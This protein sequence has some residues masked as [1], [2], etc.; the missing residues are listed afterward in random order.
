MP[1]NTQQQSAVQ[2]LPQ[3]TLTLDG[4]TLKSG[5]IQY[6]IENSGNFI[7]QSSMISAANEE[8]LKLKQKPGLIVKKESPQL[9][10]TTHQVNDDSNKKPKYNFVLQTTPQKQQ[11]Q[12][13]K[14]QQSQILTSSP[15]KAQ[16]LN[17]EKF[18]PVTSQANQVSPTKQVIVPIMV[19]SDGTRNALTTTNSDA[20]SQILQALQMSANQGLIS[21]DNKTNLNGQ[22]FML[23]KLQPNSDGQFTLMQASAQP[24]APL[25]PPP[26]PTQQLQISL[27]SQQLQQLGLQAAPPSHQQIMQ[28]QKQTIA[29]QPAQLP[30]P[31]QVTH[32]PV[33]PPHP[34]ETLSPLKEISSVAVEISQ[35]DEEMYNDSFDED[36]YGDDDNENDSDNNESHEKSIEKR[37][38][39]KKSPKASKGS[40]GKSSELYE[41]PVINPEHSDQAK[42]QLSMLT[43]FSAKKTAIEELESKNDGINMTVCDVSMLVPFNNFKLITKI[44]S[45][46]VKRFSSEKNS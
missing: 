43:S 26:A 2:G 16:I 13:P 30:V 4:G 28:Q 3:Y 11:Q 24:Q 32:R 42:K 8:F 17:I 44:S 15:P 29:V 22:P 35:D 46:F 39:K 14:V 31:T 7:N 33:S 9:R 21:S 45:R 19:R 34:S 25:A 23:M 38:S 10:L 18:L 20:T 40:K 6:K 36:F 12:Q 1:A 5:Q 27:S 37:A 41:E